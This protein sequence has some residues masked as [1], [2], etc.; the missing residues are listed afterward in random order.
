MTDLLE[1][2]I[3]ELRKRPDD[4]QDALAALILEE[5]ADEALWR[6]KFRRDADRLAEIADDV[7][8]EVRSGRTLD[9]DPTDRPI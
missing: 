5:I 7:L 3:A 9:R 4:E 6:T 8:A 2:A 1:T